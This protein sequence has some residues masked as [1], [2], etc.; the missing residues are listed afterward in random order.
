MDTAVAPLSSPVDWL[1]DRA[2]FGGAVALYGVAAAY[3]VFLWR[4]GFQREEWMTSVLLLLGGALHTLAMVKRGFSLE[5]CPVTNLFEATMFILW[6]IVAAV[7]VA[8]L[9]RRLRFLGAFAAP[10]LFGAGVFAL[11]PQLDLAGS[12]PHFDHGLVSAHAALILLAYGAFGLGSVAAL[13]YL[14]Q[15]HDLR[16]HKLRAVLA[17]LPPIQRLDRIVLGLLGAGLLLLTA[18][19]AL[20]PWLMWERY[21]VLF[22]SDPKILWSLAVWGVY[23]A[24]LVARLRHRFNGRRFAWGTLGTFAFVLLTFWGTNLLSGVHNP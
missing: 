1:T 17:R 12:R 4:R 18:G 20:S 7:L 10:L 3:A 16:F 15:D 14:S 22:S 19:L 5:R 24:L 9:W 11:Q 13:M 6:T 21:G 23:L 2:A 8:G